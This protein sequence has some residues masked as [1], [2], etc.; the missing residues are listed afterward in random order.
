MNIITDEKLY[1]EHLSFGTALRIGPFSNGSQSKGSKVVPHSSMSI[2]HRA[3][4]DF[5]AV[6]L[7]MT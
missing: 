5:L 2:G 4:P 1:R 3:D 6:S 7:Q